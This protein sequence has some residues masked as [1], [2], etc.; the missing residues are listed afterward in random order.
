MSAQVAEKDHYYTESI[1]NSYIDVDNYSSVR[2]AVEKGSRESVLKL[3]DNFFNLSLNFKSTYREEIRKTDLPEPPNETDS[4]ALYRGVISFGENRS[5]EFQ[6]LQKWQGIVHEIHFDHFVAKLID[7]T[8]GLSDEFA[9]FPFAEISED[10]MKLLD[11][12]AVFYWNV[13]Y[14]ISESKQ[15]RRTSLIRFRRLPAWGK[16]DIET[17]RIASDIIA[18]QL[19]L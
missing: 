1:S 3:V 6:S 12:G 2:D 19:G 17:G 8:N 4:E 11:F 15:K 7:L 14:Q 18:A 13:G 9:D 5:V 10:D 16:K